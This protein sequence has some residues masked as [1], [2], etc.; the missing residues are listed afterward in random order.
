M[1]DPCCKAARQQC[2][3]VRTQGGEGVDLLDAGD[4]FHAS[5]HAL[6]V[7]HIA[8]GRSRTEMTEPPTPE[9]AF[10]ALAVRDDLGQCVGLEEY[11]MLHM[12]SVCTD[13]V[14][15]RSEGAEPVPCPWVALPAFTPAHSCNGLQW[16]RLRTAI[17]GNLG[18]DYLHLS[19][20]SGRDYLPLRLL[21][22]SWDCNQRR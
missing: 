8:G 9:A 12:S 11:E 10:N 18:P 14:S 7:E 6:E 3:I 15:V 5:T 20:P 16:K 1:R 21:L 2:D 22:S 13:H 19:I 4:G 17:N